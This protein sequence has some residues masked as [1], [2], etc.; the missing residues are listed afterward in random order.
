M[1]TKKNREN[2]LY[3]LLAA[4]TC[5]M[6]AYG[7]AAFAA[8]EIDLRKWDTLA[9]WGVIWGSFIATILCVMMRRV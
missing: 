7:M 8:W 6:L 3:T 4:V 9:R 2:A 1:I 5:F